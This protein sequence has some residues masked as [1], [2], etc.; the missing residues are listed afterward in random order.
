MSDRKTVKAKDLKPGDVIPLQGGEQF[1]VDRVDIDH[2]SKE[3]TVI[4]NKNGKRC[5][6]KP[7]DNIIILKL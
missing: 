6:A 7:E 3:V 2:K 1:L 4:D 5:N